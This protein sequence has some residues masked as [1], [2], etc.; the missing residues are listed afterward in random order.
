MRGALLPLLL[1]GLMVAP[2]GAAM[3][4]FSAAEGLP[5]SACHVDPTGGGMRSGYGRAEFSATRL[6]LPGASL[7]E[8]AVPL[9]P[10]ATDSLTF[11]ADVRLLYQQLFKTDAPEPNIASFYPMQSSLYVAADLWQHATVYV[12]P[13]LTGNETLIYEASVLLNLPWEG[14]WVRAGRFTP[15][16]GYKLADHSIFVR[17]QLGLGPLDKDTGLQLGLELGS[18]NLSLSLTNGTGAEAPWDTNLAKAV[19][20]RVGWIGRFDPLRFQLGFSAGYDLDGLGAD[21]SLSGGDERV[22]DA[23]LGV[24]GAIGVGRF[25]WIGEA[26]V[27]RLDD[28]MAPD[29]VTEVVSLQQLAIQVVPGADLLL[30]W[31]LWDADIEL[32]ANGIHR[33]GA[34]FDLFPWPF[35]E[36]DVRWRL[37]LGGSKHPMTDLHELMAVAHA[38]F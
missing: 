9:D 31:E 13:T 26:D 27:R 6:H 24:F 28:R 23:R 29:A 35:V 34:G 19:F 14:A 33:V 11:G 5:C 16:Y 38:F 25:T 21:R 2:P 3:P 36:L 10:Q 18:V 4:R 8:G 32:E 30:S 17:K 12:A 7:A 15:D 22:E 1:L 37:V 20:G